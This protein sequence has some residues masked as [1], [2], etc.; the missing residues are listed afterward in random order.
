MSENDFTHINEYPNHKFMYERPKI[1]A[2]ILVSQGQIVKLEMA[3]GQID[4]NEGVNHITSEIQKLI[5]LKSIIDAEILNTKKRSRLNF[6]RMGK[7]LYD[8]LGV[9][10]NAS[11]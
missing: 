8:I 11:A 2:M 9:K 7:N 6:V 1:N 5:T 10:K 4:D 3:E